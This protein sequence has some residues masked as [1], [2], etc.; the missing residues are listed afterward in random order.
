MRAREK[1]SSDKCLK[2]SGS[3]SRKRTCIQGRAFSYH[4][5]TV[6]IESKAPLD[7]P[8]GKLGL[9]LLSKRDGAH[10]PFEDV[11]RPSA[12]SS[13]RQN[14]KKSHNVP[15]DSLILSITITGRKHIWRTHACDFISLVK[16]FVKRCNL[17]I[18]LFLHFTHIIQFKAC[19]GFPRGTQLNIIIL[20]CEQ[21]RWL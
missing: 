15:V 11:L 6:I 19:S 1:D 2:R 12:R 13:G 7:R 10:S 16:A 21:N 18:S 8:Y 4:V 17:L 5:N 20:Q 14:L 3:K 9:S